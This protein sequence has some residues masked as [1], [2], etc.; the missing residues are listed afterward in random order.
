[1]A[2]IG[3]AK[4]IALAMCALYLVGSAAQASP[5]V[6]KPAPDFRVTTFDGQHLTLKDFKGQVL[7]LNFWATWCGPCKRELPLL[8]TYYKVQKKV[9]LRVLAVTTE[10]SL[11]VSDLRPLSKA[12]VIP[13][14]REMRGGYAP[15]EGVPTNYVIDREGVV[16]Y[17]KAAAFDLDDLNDILVPLLREPAPKGFYIG[18][19]G[20]ILPIPL[21]TAPV[22]N[23][24]PALAK[25]G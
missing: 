5:V 15:L 6:G 11:P 9:G 12:L 25:G 2:L 19:D 10:D 4:R 20:V 14:V 24:A 23:V 18:P 17:A 7:V 22:A 8:D 21:E 3:L 13:M 1:M 16:R